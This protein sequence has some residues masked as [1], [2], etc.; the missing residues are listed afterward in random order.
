MDKSHVTLSLN[1]GFASSFVT[2]DQVLTLS[3]PSLFSSVK[4]KW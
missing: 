2:L 1:V 4:W 3:A